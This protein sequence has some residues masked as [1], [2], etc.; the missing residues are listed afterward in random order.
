MRPI[1]ILWGQTRFCEAGPHF[2]RPDLILWD[3]TILWDHVTFFEAQPLL[4]AI[5][6]SVRLE[7]ILWGQAW[8]C[9]TRPHSIRSG[10]IL[11]GKISFCVNQPYPVRLDL[12]RW[13][14]T[15]FCGARRYSVRP[16]LNLWPDLILWDQTSFCE[17]RSHSVRPRSICEAGL[18]TI[19]MQLA[20]LWQQIIVDF[21]NFGLVNQPRPQSAVCTIAHVM[22]ACFPTLILTPNNDTHY[23][24]SWKLEQPD[25]PEIG[26]SLSI[27]MQKYQYK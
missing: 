26:Y 11:W 24:I 13:G 19:P 2:R 10:L 12:L 6:P 18:T 20:S 9:E 16:G 27:W 8:F 7:L 1:L 15:S 25:V 3:Y 4:E 21:P 5:P 22:S 14:Q 17:D 23:F